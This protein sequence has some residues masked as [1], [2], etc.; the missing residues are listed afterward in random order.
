MAPGR[1]ARPSP[2][3]L[4]CWNLAVVGEADLVPLMRAYCDFYQVGPSDERCAPSR[5]LLVA[6]P[7]PLFEY[8]VASLA[9]ADWTALY[10]SV[11]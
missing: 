2:R 5:A 6:E 7:S 4:E 9:R 11:S 3:S 10:A 8:C 1:W